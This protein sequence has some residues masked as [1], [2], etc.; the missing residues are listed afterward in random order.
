MYTILTEDIFELSFQY[1][2]Y[3]NYQYY[4]LTFLKINILNNVGKYQ[5]Q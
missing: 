5:I 3:I 1:V 2:F 4:N